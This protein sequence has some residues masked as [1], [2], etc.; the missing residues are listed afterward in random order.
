[1][2]ALTRIFGRTETRDTYLGTA[3]Q[4]DFA[5][6][7]WLGSGEHF[8]QSVNAIRLEFLSAATA[9]IDAIAGTVASLPAIV[10]RTTANGREEDNTHPLARLVRDGP[11][12]HQ[13][14]PDFIQ[15]LVAQTLRHGN[16]LAEQ[17]FAGNQLAE[18]RPIPWDCLSA[19][20][21]L[22]GR[23]VFDFTD[24]ITLQRRR[25][26]DTECLHLRDRS[27]DGL[28]GRARHDRASPVISAA[29][30]LTQ[31]SGNQYA[32]G[33]YPSGVLQTDAKLGEAALQ[34]L[35][36]L[37]SSLFAGPSKAAKA[38]ILDQVKWSTLTATPEAMELLAARRFAVEEAARLYQ[39]PPPIIGDL[40][41][42]TFTNSETLIRFFAQSTISTWCRKIESE[43]HRSIFTDSARRTRQFE[44]D[45]SGLL[46]GDP[47][48]RWKSHEIALRNHVLTPNEI[49]DL[50]GWNPRPGGDEFPATPA[51]AAPGI[52]A[53]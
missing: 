26:L 36:A 33:A 35:Q 28:L 17:V 21:L 23:L 37:F 14:W 51:T 46:R 30:A 16:G 44:L 9:S 47:E 34:Q 31:F 7:D 49:R 1:V 41:H 15:W 4:R 48:T 43:V 53:A 19:K 8:G 40:T 50:E 38:L 25:L 13:S 2:N 42:G 18:L 11:N 32:N 3:T 27:D 52:A 29:L 10:Y 5:L 24:P 39:V 20:V 45:L 12:Q 6:V 22:D